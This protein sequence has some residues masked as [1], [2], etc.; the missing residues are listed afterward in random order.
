MDAENRQLELSMLFNW[1]QSDFGGKSGVV[2]F[3]LQHTKGQQ[4]NALRELQQQCKPDEIKF[5]YLPYD[6][7]MN[8]T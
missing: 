5:E 2:D 7:S 4:N 1:Y 6:W 3:L 8:S